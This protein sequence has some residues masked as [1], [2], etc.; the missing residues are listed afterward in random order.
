MADFKISQL[1]PLP[2]FKGTA[3][4]EVSQ[5]G[6]SWSATAAKV[7]SGT[8]INRSTVS[9]AGVRGTVA[10]FITWQPFN[11]VKGR[12]RERDMVAQIQMNAIMPDGPL[13]TVATMRMKFGATTVASWVLPIGSAQIMI[14]GTVTAVNSTDVIGHLMMAHGTSTVTNWTPILLVTSPGVVSLTLDTLFSFTV[15]LGAM[16]DS[17]QLRSAH[18][19]S[20]IAGL[21][22]P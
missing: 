20:S 13:T 11:I 16:I 10:E 2:T 5:D 17:W 4:L 6:S 14:M 1:P 21:S 19:F 3:L 12:M 15:Q 18:A 22:T 9:N 8:V 7:M